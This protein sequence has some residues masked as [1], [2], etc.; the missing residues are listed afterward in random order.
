[1]HGSAPAKEVYKVVSPLG[2]TAVEMVPPVPRLK[3]L[4]G[5]TICEIWNGG[6]KGN[7]SFPILRGMLKERYPHIKIIPYTEF[8][9]TSIASLGPETR[10]KV[11]GAVEEAIL[12][13]GCEAVITGNGA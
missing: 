3:T 5:K 11:L 9:L 2:K 7:E 13:S 12:K 1:M 8:P 4:E 6:F 10:E